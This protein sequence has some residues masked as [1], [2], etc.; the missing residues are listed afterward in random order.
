MKSLIVAAALLVLATSAF[1]SPR[2]PTPTQLKDIRAWEDAHEACVYSIKPEVIKKGCAMEARLLPKLKTQGFCFYGHGVVGRRGKK[3][4]YPGFDAEGTNA[5]W[6][7][8]CYEL[9]RPR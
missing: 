8:H 9:P 4:W 7:R 6:A 1:A 2:H 5:H 3:Y